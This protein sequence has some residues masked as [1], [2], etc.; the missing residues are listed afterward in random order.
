MKIICIPLQVSK[1]I[2]IRFISVIPAYLKDELILRCSNFMCDH[3]LPDADC[4]TPT[5]FATAESTA[6]LVSF[7]MSEI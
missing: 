6:N 1:I 2:F 5:V 3:V 4:E 7:E